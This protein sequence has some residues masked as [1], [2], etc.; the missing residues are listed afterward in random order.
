MCSG[1]AQQQGP[2]ARAAGAGPVSRLRR[3]DAGTGPRVAPVAERD[4]PPGGCGSVAAAGLAVA[5]EQRY[6]LP[7]RNRRGWGG[8]EQQS[9]EVALPHARPDVVGMPGVVE[10]VGVGVERDARPSM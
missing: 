6:T 10:Q 3:R 7:C 1:L 8:A 5:A 4:R 9:A 2:Y